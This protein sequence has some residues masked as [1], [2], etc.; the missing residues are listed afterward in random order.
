[1]IFRTF[2]IYIYQSTFVISICQN[3]GVLYSLVDNVLG[4]PFSKI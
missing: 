4:T 3:F 2:W 1:M